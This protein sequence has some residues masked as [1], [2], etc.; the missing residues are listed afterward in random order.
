MSSDGVISN[1]IDCI[2][3]SKTE[4]GTNL[5]LRRCMFRIENARKIKQTLNDKDD[6]DLEHSLGKFITYGERI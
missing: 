1:R 3:E 2:P 5:L 6:P 4:K